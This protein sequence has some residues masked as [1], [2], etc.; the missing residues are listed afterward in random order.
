MAV[1]KTLA[2][3]SVLA[4]A[5][6]QLQVPIVNMDDFKTGSASAAGGDRPLVDSERL[7][8]LINT[9]NLLKRANELYAIAELSHDEY[10]HP[11]RV[12]GSLGA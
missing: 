5:S 9:D 3:A 6:A 8:E 12:I 11:T 10:N 4:V 7:Q 2:V 1:L